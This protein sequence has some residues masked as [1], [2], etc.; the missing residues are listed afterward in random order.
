MIEDL[1]VEGGAGKVGCFVLW[2]PEMGSSSLRGCGAGFGRAVEAFVIL[3]EG[4]FQ[5]W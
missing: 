1:E 5:I 4:G 2:I 3:S